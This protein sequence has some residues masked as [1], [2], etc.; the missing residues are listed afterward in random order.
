MIYLPPEY[1]QNT[2]KKYP[3]LYLQHGHGENETCWVSQGK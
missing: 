2:E 1:M 3:V